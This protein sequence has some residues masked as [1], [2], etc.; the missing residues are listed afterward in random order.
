MVRLLIWT[1]F[2]PLP[3]RM[4]CAKFGWNWPSTWFS[5][6]R[7]FNFVNVFSLFCNYLPLKKVRGSSFKQTWIPFNQGCIVPSL[8]K[9]DCHVVLE[10]KILKFCQ[11]TYFRY[12]LII[13]PWKRAGNLFVKTWI[14]FIGGCIVPSLIEV[15][16]QW[17]WRRIYF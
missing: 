9:I 7:F 10:K 1:S 8:V 5:R 2:P 3:P 15:L 11:C 4:L 13:S 6:R 16:V 14:P 17:F 12:F